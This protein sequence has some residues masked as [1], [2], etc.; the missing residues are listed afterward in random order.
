MTNPL[1]RFA[2]PGDSSRQTRAKNRRRR[3]PPC[4]GGWP[5]VPFGPPTP[6][7]TTTAIVAEILIV[8]L[9]ASAWV[10]LLVGWIY[11]TSLIHEGLWR[12]WEGLGTILILAT[13]Y[14]LGIVIDRLA[15]SLFRR[16][17][18][19]G[20]GG[21]HRRQRLQVMRRDD[22]VSRFLEYQRSRLRI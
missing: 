21:G 12:G 22:P 19:L 10:A 15:D 13:A 7:M 3:S 4:D 5:D 9:Q 18:W 16:I 17:A 1:S 6:A 8:G 20:G 2:L 11:G 14:S